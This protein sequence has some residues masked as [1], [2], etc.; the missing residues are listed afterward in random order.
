MSIVSLL[1]RA[2]ET[3]DLELPKFARREELKRPELIELK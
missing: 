2:V 1:Q 3:L